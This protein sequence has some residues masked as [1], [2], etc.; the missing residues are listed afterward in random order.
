MDPVFGVD[1]ADVGVA[2]GFRA[3]KVAGF[4]DGV[5]EEFV[6]DQAEFFGGKDVGA[7]IEVVAFV[8]DEF[9]GQHGIIST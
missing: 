7:E 5:V 2:S 6:V 9:E 4:G 8:V 1:S 3:E